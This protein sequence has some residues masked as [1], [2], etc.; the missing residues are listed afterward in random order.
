[1][2]TLANRSQDL[3]DAFHVFSQV[4][5]RLAESYRLLEDRVAGLNQELAAARHERLQQLAEK[6]RLANRLQLLLATLPAG[7]WYSTAKAAFKN[8]IPLLPLC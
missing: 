1:M 6:E 8:A 7:W 3:E 5:E 4:S 2:P